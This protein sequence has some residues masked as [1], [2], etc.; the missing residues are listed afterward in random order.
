MSGP[1]RY[2][3]RLVVGW[4]TPVD[5]DGGSRFRMAFQPGAR[6][7]AEW[8]DGQAFARRPVDGSFDEGSAQTMPLQL[9]RYF[10]V[11]QHQPVGSPAV[12]EL[13]DGTV[14][15]QLEAGFRFVVGNPLVRV[16]G[17][18][19]ASRAAWI[20]PAVQGCAGP[21]GSRRQPR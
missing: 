5:V 16:H 21:A 9:L 13:A 19:V 10:G 15:S 18:I 17:T 4:L 2:R 12:N 6:E 8:D 3:P 11:D 1:A 20:T 7:R 14:G